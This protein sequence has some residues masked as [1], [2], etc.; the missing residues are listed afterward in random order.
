MEA[1]I[2]SLVAG[3]E[4]WLGDVVDH[5]RSRWARGE[6]AFGPSPAEVDAARET[7]LILRA[8]A[9]GE[10]RGKAHRTFSIDV[11]GR[12]KALEDC[13]SHVVAALRKVFSIDEGIGPEEILE[14]AGLQKF[15]QPVLIRA[16]I[17][18]EGIQFDLRPYIGLPPEVAVALRP[19]PGFAPYLLG[20][21]NLTTFNR[22]VRESPSGKELNRLN[23]M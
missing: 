2:G 20:I 7:L 9:S 21:E 10:H 16:S 3:A 15:H 11:T 17:E 1:A 4:P 19:K 22:Y 5:C 13:R 12:S 6:A 8:I 14:A 18:I 23:R